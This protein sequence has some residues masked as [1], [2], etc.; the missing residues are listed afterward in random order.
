ML[1]QLAVPTTITSSRASLIML[2]AVVASQVAALSG[3]VCTRPA[4]RA[5][6]VS[7]ARRVVCAEAEAESNADEGRDSGV[8]GARIIGFAGGA[9]AGR[10][11][12]LKLVLKSS[13]LSCTCHCCTQRYVGGPPRARRRAVSAYLQGAPARSPHATAPAG[14]AALPPQVAGPALSDLSKA[15]ESGGASIKV[16]RPTL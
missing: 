12:K 2:V 16:S 11:A 1:P 6:V 8:R 15:V 13:L 14:D 10:C 4:L 3:P 9:V 7:R 5:P